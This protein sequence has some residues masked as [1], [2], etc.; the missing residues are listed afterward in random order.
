M[1]KRVSKRRLKTMREKAAEL[2]GWFGLVAHNERKRALKQAF[3]KKRPARVL[4]SSLKEGE[5]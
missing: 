1:V 2:G 3:K 5:Q 4:A